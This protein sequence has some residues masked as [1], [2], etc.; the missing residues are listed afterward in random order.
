[1]NAFGVTRVG[2]PGQQ[3]SH[4]VGSLGL[5]PNVDQGGAAV[6][7]EV[8]CRHRNADQR[9]VVELGRKF[10]RREDAGDRVP[11]AAEPD[12]RTAGQVGDA[13]RLCRGVAEHGGRV[14][15]RGL[16]EERSVGELS[17]QCGQ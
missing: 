16:V 3:A 12:A 8:N 17:A 14:T 5:R 4:V 13:Q 11:F 9:G 15:D 10:Q 6:V 2:D 1:V 7:A